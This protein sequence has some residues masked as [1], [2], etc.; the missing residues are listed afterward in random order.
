MELG[1]EKEEENAQKRQENKYTCIPITF[2]NSSYQ[3]IAHKIKLLCIKARLTTWP[4]TILLLIRL[5]SLS[6]KEMH[7]LGKDTEP[8]NQFVQITNAVPNFK[9]ATALVATYPG[10]KF[11]I[12]S[13]LSRFTWQHY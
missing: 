13:E 5:L 7:K 9:T 4:G 3:H 6:L 12:I 2:L 11:L 10:S 1:V 8:L